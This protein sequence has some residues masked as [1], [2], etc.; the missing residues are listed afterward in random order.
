M[1]PHWYSN[2]LKMSITVKKRLHRIYKSSLVLTAVTPT[3]FA[4]ARTVSKVLAT[5]C[6]NP[7]ISNVHVNRE[8]IYISTNPKILVL[9]GPM[10]LGV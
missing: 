9:G 3:A 10:L 2:D 1:F 7:Y 5:G 4:K 6:F 8:D